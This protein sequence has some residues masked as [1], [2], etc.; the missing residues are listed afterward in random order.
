M[1]QIPDLI[2]IVSAEGKILPCLAAHHAASV[3]VVVG[4]GE[5]GV[6]LAQLRLIIVW[7]VA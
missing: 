2:S 1:R 4:D 3:A 7:V 6:H 5:D